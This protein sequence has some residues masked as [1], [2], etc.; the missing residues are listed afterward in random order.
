M[1]LQHRYVFSTLGAGKPHCDVI[2]QNKE[3]HFLVEQKWKIHQNIGRKSMMNPR[4]S[5]KLSKNWHI[6]VR[7]NCDSLSR[8]KNFVLGFTA[9]ARTRTRAL[10]GFCTFNPLSAAR[11]IAGE[12]IALRYRILHMGSIRF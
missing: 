2:N 12:K 8:L 11:C 1:A 4:Q 5:F 10:M 7:R 3:K 9:R 6:K